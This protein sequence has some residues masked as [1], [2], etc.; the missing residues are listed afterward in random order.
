MA[1]N[2]DADLLNDTLSFQLTNQGIALDLGA[3]TTLCF[4]DTLLLDAGNQIGQINWLG[5]GVTGRFFTVTSAGNYIAEVTDNG[6]TTSDTISVQFNL[7]IGLDLGGDQSICLG[8]SV[9]LQG[10]ITQAQSFLWLQ[11]GDTTNSI[12]AN[13]AGIY[14]LEILLNQCSAR[15]TV[16][17]LQLA[18]P[19]VPTITQVGDT[20]FSTQ[21]NA[22]ARFR[23]DSLILNA[24]LN[25][26]VPTQ[27]GNYTV[28]VTNVDGCT[29]ISAPYFYQTTG[30]ALQEIVIN[31]YPNPSNG[32]VNISNSENLQKL[33][34]LNPQGQQLIR[35]N[36]ITAGVIQVDLSSL[37]AGIYWVKVANKFGAKTYQI[38][39]LGN[40]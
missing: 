12:W 5:T 8:D 2:F 6:C 35:M 30:I 14:V 16:E 3:D 1:E 15:D 34:I 32:I 29:E 39:K 26:L 21:E 13:A 23:N 9:Q 36:N 10:N 22:Y 33:E 11:T 4:G 24:N 28:Q 17:V 18:S 19:A 20:L 25:F 40:S 7:A 38:V 31:I 37:A 27:N